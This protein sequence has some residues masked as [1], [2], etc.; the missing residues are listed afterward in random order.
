MLSYQHA[1][2]AGNMADV[3]KHA[4]LS[5][6]LDYLVQKPKPL[7]YMESHA[8]RGLY[9]LS[10]AEALKTGEAV[11]G[12]AR[13]QDRFPPDHPYM[14]ALGAI[15]DTAGADAYPGSPLIART[16]LRGED[17]ITLG[18][19]H[20][21]EVAA[22]RENVRSVHIRQ[23]DGVQMLL[24]L[25]PPTPR[26]GVALIDP[27]YEI[28]DEWQVMPK[29]LRDLHRKWPVGVLMLWYPILSNGMHETL[30]GTLPDL[31]EDML[32]HQLNFAAARP[33]HGMIGSGMVVINPPW[34][35][36]HAVSELESYLG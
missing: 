29:L 31:A 7:S 25:A 30:T 34:G 19:M 26:R 2:H 21:Q 27:S 18:E 23:T 28:K 15:R 1:Y 20:P 12:I 3:H 5:F 6:V 16:L 35:L 32:H 24:S 17:T 11:A 13:V 10:G 4:I 8:G 36:D 14:R 22:L 33:G 9:D